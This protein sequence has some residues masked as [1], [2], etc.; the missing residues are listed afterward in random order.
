M[1]INPAIILKGRNSIKKMQLARINAS[2]TKN[3]ILWKRLYSIWYMD[4]KKKVRS[5]TRLISKEKKLHI[6]CSCSEKW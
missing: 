1:I 5:S 2:I 4:A 6:Y 3:E